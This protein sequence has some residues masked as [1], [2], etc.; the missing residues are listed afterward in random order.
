MR[1]YDLNLK[2]TKEKERNSPVERREKKEEV[3]YTG[4]GRRRLSMTQ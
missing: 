1:N 2:G 4:K 3:Q